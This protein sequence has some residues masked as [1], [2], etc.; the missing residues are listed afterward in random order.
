MV[1]PRIESK[2]VYQIRLCP[3]DTF[4]LLR[5]AW[6]W[7]CKPILKV[8][9]TCHVAWFLTF[10]SHIST[11]PVNTPV[12]AKQS[13]NNSEGKGH[14]LLYFEFN[15]VL[16]HCIS[17]VCDGLDIVTFASSE[18]KKKKIGQSI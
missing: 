5:I 2:A 12:I 7:P 10:H 14:C 6:F 3:S 4:T 18:E 16:V 13:L 11:L 1:L 9:M 8:L 17:I 15:V